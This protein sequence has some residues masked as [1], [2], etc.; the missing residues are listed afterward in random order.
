MTKTKTFSLYLGT[1]LLRSLDEIMT[2]SAHDLVENGFAKRLTSNGL[3]DESVLFTFPGRRSPPK[4]VSHLSEIFAIPTDL[5]SQSP[6]AVVVFKKDQKIFAITFSYGHVYL[7]ESKTEADFGLKVAINKLSDEKLRSVEHSHIGDAI[8]GFSQAAGQ[9]DLRSF[10]FDEALDLIRKVSGYADD[11][12]FADKITGSRALRFSKSVLM[13]EIPNV[14]MEALRLFSLEKYKDTAF[15]IIDFL[16]PVL[17]SNLINTLDSELIKHLINDSGEF[18]IAIPEILPTSIGYFSFVNVGIREFF[19][20]ISIDIYRKGLGNELEKLDIDLL[21]KHKIAVHSEAGD[22]LEQWS[23]RRAL[24][25]SVVVGTARYALNEGVWYRLDDTYKAAADE[26]FIALLRAPDPKFTPLRKIYT[27]PEKRKRIKPY[28]QSEESYNIEIASSSGYLLMDQKLVEIAE[29]PGRGIEACD[30]LDI[31]G[32]RFIHIKK[33]SRQSSILSHFFKQGSNAAQ[34]LRTYEPF[35][36]ALVQR[37]SDLHGTEAAER[38]KNSLDERWTVEFQIAD[39]PRRDGGFDIPFFSKL[40]L[41]DEV[42]HMEA[43]RF[44]VAIR[45]I[46]LAPAK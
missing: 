16:S 21:K 9:R 13:S 45:F 38:L 32:R 12:D 17:D 8:R 19:P 7:D 46:K 42:R 37:V 44:N 1:E 4:W 14:A 28:Y 18:E 20:D 2:T 25:G 3:G 29:E 34:M 33:S 6:C 35:R 39:A 30:L 43:M 23:I 27:P 11:D 40:T 31:E 15:K 24:V 36:S 41:R 10:G 26:K 22:K 5:V